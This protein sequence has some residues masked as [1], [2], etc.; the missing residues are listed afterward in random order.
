MSI[1]NFMQTDFT[2]KVRTETKVDGRNKMSYI[3]D[4]TI[5]KCA[6]FTPGT[7]KTVRFGKQDF[8]IGKNLY[9]RVS[10]PIK[11]GDIIIVKGEEYDTVSEVDT[12][13][14]EHHRAIGLVSRD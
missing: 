11:L 9:C 2:V 4:G 3:D 13:C 5:Y 14:I 8:I 12:N 10:V 6:I 7:E 1:E